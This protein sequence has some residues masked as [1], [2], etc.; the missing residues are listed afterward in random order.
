[1]T[2]FQ[3]KKQTTMCHD[4]TSP[5]IRAKY[6]PPHSLPTWL[7]NPDIRF[8]YSTHNFKLFCAFFWYLEQSIF[9][10]FVQGSGTIQEKNTYDMLTKDSPRGWIHL[11][12][13]PLT[14]Y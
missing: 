2:F 6:K 8:I 4:Q 5:L 10:E 1:M 7:D 9:Q 13:Q 3:L 14:R 12:N 11:I